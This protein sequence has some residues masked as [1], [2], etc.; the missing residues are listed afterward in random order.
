MSVCAVKWSGTLVGGGM[1]YSVMNEVGT[2]EC[3]E[4]VGGDENCRKVGVKH[5]GVDGDVE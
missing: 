4:G 5:W 2:A 3:A 1:E